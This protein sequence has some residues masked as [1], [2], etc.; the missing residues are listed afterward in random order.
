[1]EQGKHLTIF[2]APIVMVINFCI[3]GSH[4]LM[5]TFRNWCWWYSADCLGYQDPTQV[6][7]VCKGSALPAVL[8]S[9]PVFWYFILFHICIFLPILKPH[10]T[11]LFIVNSKIFHCSLSRFHGLFYISESSFSREIKKNI[12]FPF[13]YRCYRNWT[14]FALNWKMFRE[15]IFSGEREGTHLVVAGGAVV[16]GT[17]SQTFWV[18]ILFSIQSFELCPQPQNLH[19]INTSYSRNLSIECTAFQL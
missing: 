4:L 1:M 5:L 10:L 12:Q 3:L 13:I 14:K 16:L 6:G 8:L 7:A 17:D 18:Q 19:Y 15:I 2:L 11:C 9:S